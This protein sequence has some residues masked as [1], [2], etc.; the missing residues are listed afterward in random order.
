MF[1]IFQAQG[2]QLLAPSA[3]V[4]FMLFVFFVIVLRDIYYSIQDWR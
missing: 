3:A 2:K 4:K 1:N